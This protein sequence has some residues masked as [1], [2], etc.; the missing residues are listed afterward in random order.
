MKIFFKEAEQYVTN[1]LRL[2]IIYTLE[3]EPKPFSPILVEAPSPE[4]ETESPKSNGSASSNDEDYSCDKHGLSTFEEIAKKASENLSKTSLFLKPSSLT[5]IDARPMTVQID[6]DGTNSENQEHIEQN[7]QSKLGKRK[8]NS[9]NSLSCT[10]V[11]QSLESGLK[12]MKK[13]IS[14]NL[15]HISTMERE[16]N[17]SRNDNIIL[18]QR[19]AELEGLVEQLNQEKQDLLNN[20]EKKTCAECGEVVD[21]VVFCNSE[22]HEK[23]IK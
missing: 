18:R 20:K 5:A 12:R 11:T 1:L 10:S 15:V 6:N 22:C 23:N 9:P 2:K 3:E 13:C 16:L 21:T 7:A 19:I 8:A 4:F 14:E 17:F